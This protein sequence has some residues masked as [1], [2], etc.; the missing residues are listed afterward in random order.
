VLVRGRE[1][2][3]GGG[4]KLTWYFYDAAADGVSRMMGDW[5]LSI[6]QSPFFPGPDFSTSALF[7]IGYRFLSLN[8]PVR[9]S[10]LP[11]LSRKARLT[12]ILMLVDIISLMGL[13]KPFIHPINQSSNP[14]RWGVRHC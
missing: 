12:K 1:E 7:G 5:I 11:E 6:N 8:A 10:R 14:K 2:R 9:D 4:Y 3:R 13:R